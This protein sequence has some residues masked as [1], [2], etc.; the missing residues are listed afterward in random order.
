LRCEHGSAGISGASD[1]IEPEFDLVRIEPEFDLVRIEPEF[2]LVRIEPEFD[3]VWNQPT[4]VGGAQTQ[5]Q[6]GG[7]RGHHRGDVFL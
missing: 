6:S 5:E 7:C 1:R 2:D 4:E 3:L